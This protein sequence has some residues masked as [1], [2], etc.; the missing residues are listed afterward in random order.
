VNVCRFNPSLKKEEIVT[1]TGEKVL[2]SVSYLA[3]SGG[4]SCISI[5]RTGDKNPFFIIK[6]A[7]L[8]GVNDLTWGLEGNILFGCSNDG[9]VMSCHFLPGTLGAFANEKEKQE[10]ILKNY[11]E[12]V[13]SDYKKTIRME[14]AELPQQVQGQDPTVE[15]KQI[16]SQ[17]TQAK[18]RIIP[19]AEKKAFASELDPHVFKFKYREFTKQAPAKPPVKKN[20]EEIKILLPNA[21]STSLDDRIELN[22]NSDVEMEDQNAK[23]STYKSSDS[24]PDGTLNLDVAQNSKELP[25][26]NGQTPLEDVQNGKSKKPVIIYV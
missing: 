24:G 22:K 19:I 10:I 20:Y 7:F 21:N 6:K 23:K 14:F 25:L 18:K 5:W 17:G 15:T 9:E 16:T 2:T 12:I 26:E 11:G 4:D 3:T 1:A 13:Y 8:A